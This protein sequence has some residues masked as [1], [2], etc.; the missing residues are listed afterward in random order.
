MRL[1]SD[2]SQTGDIILTKTEGHATILDHDELDPRHPQTAGG[3]RSLEIRLRRFAQRLRRE[4][5]FLISLGRN[6]LKSPDSQK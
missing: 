1:G 6:P 5:N 3:E 2:N 4:P